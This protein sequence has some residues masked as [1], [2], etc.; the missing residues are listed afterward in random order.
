VFDR[1]GYRELAARQAVERIG[2]SAIV[3]MDFLF[4]VP[5]GRISK[6]WWADAL[7]LFL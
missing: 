5:V 6:V 2:F 7:H 3:S 4:G 1:L